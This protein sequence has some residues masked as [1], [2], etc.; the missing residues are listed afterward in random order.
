MTFIA[1]RCDDYIVP[2]NLVTMQC[3]CMGIRNVGTLTLYK[4]TPSYVL[5]P[6][7]ADTRLTHV[8]LGLQI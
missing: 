4:L 3:C 2:S 8:V 7:Y 1:Q 6:Y 5:K